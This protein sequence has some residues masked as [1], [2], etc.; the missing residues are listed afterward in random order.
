MPVLQTAVEGPLVKQRASLHHLGFVV[1]SI[2]QAAGPFATAMSATWDGEIIH[3]PVQQVRVSFFWP[4]DARNPV[5]EL[6]EPAEPQTPVSSFLQKGGGLHHV[7]YEVDDLDLA[8]REAKT[9][10]FTVA[11]PPAPAIAF[12]D[13]RIAWVCS[14]RR[15]LMEFLERERA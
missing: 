10:G 9:V 6:V 11:S 5:F 3:D 1:G 7:C 8:L 2:A 15:M 14:R 4:F 12:H 13:R